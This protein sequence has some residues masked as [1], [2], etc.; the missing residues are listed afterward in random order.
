MEHFQFFTNAKLFSYSPVETGLFVRYVDAWTLVGL[1]FM[2][3]KALCLYA[4]LFCDYNL[5][6]ILY[7]IKSSLLFLCR[8]LLS[9]E[10]YIFFD[11]NLIQHIQFLLK[12]DS[13][14]WLLISSHLN[15]SWLPKAC[16]R[17]RSFEHLEIDKYGQKCVK[18]Y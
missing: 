15:C 8:Y 11:R 1:P 18:E 3:H 6:L 13:D 2:F 9:A 7:L 14:T 12:S 5:C 4:C 10:W 16:G 17:F